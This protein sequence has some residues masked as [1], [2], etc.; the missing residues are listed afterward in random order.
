MS[1]MCRLRFARQI[2]LILLGLCLPVVLIAACSEESPD[3]PE[4]TAL[5]RVSI[6]APEDGHV[7]AETLYVELSIDSDES[8]DRA[9][10]LIDSQSV[11]TLWE[12]PWSFDWSI[13]RQGDSS[14]V[15]AEAVVY[16]VQGRAARS[17]KVRVMLV[18]NHSPLVRIL[19]PH[20]D[21]HIP[22]AKIEERPWTCLAIDPDEGELSGDHLTWMEEGREIL[23]TGREII[24]SSLGLGVHF[25]QVEA[26]DSWGRT[27]VHRQRVIIFNYPQGDDPSDLART[28]ELAFRA[29][30]VETLEKLLH[31]ELRMLSC[32]SSESSNCFGD[33][34]LLPEALYREDIVTVFTQILEDQ[35]LHQV[36]WTWNVVATEGAETRR[37]RLVKIEV[38]GFDVILRLWN[39]SSLE[40]HASRG[41]RARFYLLEEDSAWKIWE[42]L[43]LPSRSPYPEDADFFAFLAQRIS[44]AGL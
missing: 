17:E 11:A 25:I 19:Y 13:D 22:R 12:P 1:R 23:G 24:P 8:I 31:S 35:N 41:N 15:D 14:W 39:E 10:L 32:S 38:D 33:S 26:R 40:D 16:D 27:G 21:H 9:V 44:S 20:P 7:T 43:I 37:G 30:E 34:G 3:A 18:P 4:S 2:R 42:W 36:S 28:F 5:P 29:R 6:L